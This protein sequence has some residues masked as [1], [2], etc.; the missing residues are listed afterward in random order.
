MQAQTEKRRRK[1][2]GTK[3][4]LAESKDDREEEDEDEEEEDEEEEEEEEEDDEEEHK[5]ISI[6]P[7]TY[8]KLGHF[9]LLL[10]DY[11]KGTLWFYNA[12]VQN[13]HAKRLTF[14]ILK[15]L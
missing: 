9:H 11:N 12:N 7:K 15:F 10:E 4:S 13:F 8:C 5:G 3:L 1:V 14:A 2:D 6:D